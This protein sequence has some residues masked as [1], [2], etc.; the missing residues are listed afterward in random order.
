M[1]Y[2]KIT[3]FALSA[4]VMVMALVGSPALAAKAAATPTGY[5]VSW[6][7]CGT[8]L[9]TGQAFAIVGVNNG[10]ANNT[11]PCFAQQL[12][13]AGTSSGIA[14]LPNLPKVMLYVNT[15][16]PGGLNTASWP[17]NNV[18][19]RGNTSNNPYGIC[20]H[21]NT[22]ACAYQYGW[23]RAVEDVWNRGVQNPP[24]YTWWLDV[25]T[26]NTWDT[27]AGGTARNAADLEGMTAY[28]QSVGA[29]VG[30]YSTSTQWKSIVGTV[31]ITSNLNGL[32]NWRAGATTLNGAKSNCSL[33]PLTRGGRVVMA[34]YVPGSL[35]YDYACGS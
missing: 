23:N 32:D 20:N 16:N 22:A 28:F 21:D 9:P 18:D 11:N 33:A 14:S 3:L 24:A 34:Q 5:D 4:L 26:E 15:A 31:S 19:P 17:S 8:T 27:T 7:Q 12:A 2:S 10:L 35:D 6:P 1:I 30:L 25:E 13:W 29:R